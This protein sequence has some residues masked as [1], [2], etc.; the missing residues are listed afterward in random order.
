MLNLL[1][2]LK[3]RGLGILFITHDLSLGNYISD[4]T[5]ILRRGRV[6]ELGPTPKVFGDP[7][8]SYTRT[9]LSCVP[10]LHR[11]WGD[12]AT[13]GANGGPP[14]TADANGGLVAVDD[15]HFVAPEEDAA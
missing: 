13:V 14:A 15:D 6:V 2:D 10:Q 3:G 11:K 12:G 9:L 7:R 8:H 5:L 1:G 4:R